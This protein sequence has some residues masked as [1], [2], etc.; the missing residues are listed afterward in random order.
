MTVRYH[1]PRLGRNPMT[2]E[3]IDTPEKYIPHFKPGVA[4]RELVN[5]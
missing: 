2:G 3:S 1:A 5:K 4:L